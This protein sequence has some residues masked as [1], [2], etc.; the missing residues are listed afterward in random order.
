MEFALE[1]TFLAD[2]LDKKNAAFERIRAWMA[3]ANNRKLERM[4]AREDLAM[5]IRQ[6]DFAHARPAA[7][8]ILDISPDDPLANWAIGMDFYMQGQYVRAQAYLERCLESRP[9]DPVVLNNLA[10][11]RLRL[12]DP[13]GA[14][15]YAERA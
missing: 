2:E 10:Q 12:G 11:C 14:F 1:E 9:N 5:R 8:S 13:A 7:L 4:T 15:P 3:W 6:R